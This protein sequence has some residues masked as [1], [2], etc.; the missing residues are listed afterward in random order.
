MSTTFIKIR[1]ILHKQFS[2]HYDQIQFET[3]LELE[4]GMD[5]IEMVELLNELE[6]TFK[7]K[8]NLDDI[9]LLIAKK[10]IITIKDIVNYFD[11]K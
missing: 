8:I 7:I 11:A 4:L 6:L 9:D 1:N 5:S 3:K 10:R 2:F